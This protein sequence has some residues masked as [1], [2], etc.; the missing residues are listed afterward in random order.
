MRS[1]LYSIESSQLQTGPVATGKRKPKS[2]PKTEKE[3]NTYKQLFY[4]L[5]VA[6]DLPLVL[7]RKEMEETHG[8]FASY[9][10]CVLQ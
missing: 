1:D 6:E 7:V 3:L 8:F 9:V 5:Y 10:P 4:Q 2:R